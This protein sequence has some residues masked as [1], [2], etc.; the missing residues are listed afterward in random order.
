[1]ALCPGCGAA[2]CGRSNA[3][4]GKSCERQEEPRAPD[5]AQWSGC[6]A[7]KACSKPITPI[8]RGEAL[9]TGGG[10]RQPRIPSHSPQ[11]RQH[12]CDAEVVF[13]QHGRQPAEHRHARGV[14]AQLRRHGAAQLASCRRRRQGLAGDRRHGAWL[15]TPALPIR[16]HRIASRGGAGVGLER[17]ARA[18]RASLS[19][20]SL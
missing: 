11:Q 10:A 16:E 14:Q 4:G 13:G 20:P 6:C 8:L 7:C 2:T 19:R 5:A 3:G 17:N 1:M 9:G 18:R 12:G 15:G